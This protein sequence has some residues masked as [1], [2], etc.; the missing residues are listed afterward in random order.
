M[1]YMLGNYREIPM[2]KTCVMMYLES[3]IKVAFRTTHWSRANHAEISSQLLTS[4]ASISENN[5]H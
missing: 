3:E 2:L 5:F 1:N 4:L